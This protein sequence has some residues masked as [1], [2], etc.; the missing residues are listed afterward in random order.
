MPIHISYL[1]LHSLTQPLPKSTFS[2]Y[3]VQYNNIMQHNLGQYLCIGEYVKQLVLV[4]VITQASQYRVHIIGSLAQVSQNYITNFMGHNL[5]II[6]VRNLFFISL[7]GI[8]TYVIHLLVLFEHRCCVH[9]LDTNVICLFVLFRHK[10]CVSIRIVYTGKLC[11]RF[12]CLNN[13]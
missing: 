3:I 1:G 6:V 8:D 13:A 5:I 7:Y 2:Q 12:L 9:Y 11:T 10:C 4:Q